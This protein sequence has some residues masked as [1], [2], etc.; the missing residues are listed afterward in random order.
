MRSIF[1]LFLA[2]TSLFASAQTSSNHLYSE[3][4][5]SNVQISAM[6]HDSQMISTLSTSHGYGF[7][8]GLFVGG[9]TGIIYNPTYGNGVKNRI[10]IPIFGEVKYSFLNKKVS[11]FVDLKAGGLFDYS[12]YGVGY[13]L[14]PSVGVDFWKLSLC[15]GIERLSETYATQGLKE[16]QPAMIGSR[17][18]NTGFF[19][20]LSF[21]F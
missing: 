17:G 14:K 7:G 13:V 16:G 15:A 12:A 5:K 19:V 3:G 8:N 10:Q 6:F 21:N 18:E 20:G 2:L 9:G 4:Y 1:I 11:P